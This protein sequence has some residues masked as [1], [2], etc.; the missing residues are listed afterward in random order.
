MGGRSGDG[1]KPAS[2]LKKGDRL[3]VAAGGFTEITKLTPQK[4]EGL[5]YNFALP[6]D[7]TKDHLVV[8]NGLVTGDLFLQEQLAKK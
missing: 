8:A 3:P 6:G 2:A 4:Y 1:L 5:V 7:A